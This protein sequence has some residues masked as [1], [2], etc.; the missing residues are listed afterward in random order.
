MLELARSC[1]QLRAIARPI[2][3]PLCNPWSPPL[4][5]VGDLFATVVATLVR[6]ARRRAL[7]SVTSVRT[8]SSEIQA[9]A[10]PQL[11]SSELDCH[12]VSARP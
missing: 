8:A 9:A 6:A 2:V 7:A 3:L 10:R 4:S 1:R 12:V 5:E 11:T